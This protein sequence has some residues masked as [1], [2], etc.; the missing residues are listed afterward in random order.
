[1]CLLL[2]HCK[3]N[4]PPVLLNSSS[5]EACHRV[6]SF[7]GRGPLRGQGDQRR[8]RLHSRGARLGDT[9]RGGPGDRAG[10]FVRPAILCEGDTCSAGRSDQACCQECFYVSGYDS[11]MGLAQLIGRPATRDCSFV[12]GMKELHAVPFCLTNIPQTV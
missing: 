6:G 11:T 5:A 10:S 1:M 2:A 12:S 7:P 9:A 4:Q 3:E 8:V